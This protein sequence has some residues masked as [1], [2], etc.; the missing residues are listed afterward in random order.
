MVLQLNELLKVA[1]FT[2]SEVKAVH[3]G[4]L[5]NRTRESSSDREL[6]CQLA[7]LVKAPPERLQTVFLKSPQKK[8]FDPNVQ[9]VGTMEGEGSLQDF[10]R[11]KLGDFYKTY[12]KAAPGSDLNLSSGEIH[13]FQAMGK[14]ANQVQVEAQFRQTLLDRFRAYRAG[15]LDGIL[16][17]TRKGSVDFFPG[18]ELHHQIEVAAI[19]KQHSPRF[20]KY[21]L[22]YPK[23]KPE[24]ATES[25]FWMTSLIDDK[26]TVVL[27]H[28]IGMQEGDLFVYL[29]R[30]FYVSRSHNSVQ[31]IGGA[32]PVKDG[33]IMVYVTRTSTDQVSGFGSAAKRGIGARMMMGRQAE[34]FERARTLP[35][36]ADLHI[37]K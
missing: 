34:N 4:T 19:L 31:G 32:F 6:A 26:P 8:N 16:P 28:H 10:D 33:T 20:H 36:V 1:G 2:E 25:F 35:N 18:K 3:D 22:E 13:A 14:R 23:H 15:G 24:G 17:Y 9:E 11:V 30:H 12:L 21:V 7:F 29:E 27:Y 5:I 37:K